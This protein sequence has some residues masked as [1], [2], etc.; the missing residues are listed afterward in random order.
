MRQGTV[1]TRDSSRLSI[2]VLCRLRYVIPLITSKEQLGGR[3]SQFYPSL[4]E[5]KTCFEFHSSKTLKETSAG[6]LLRQTN[7][8][9]LTIFA[10][11][12][13]Q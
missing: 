5:D 1:V 6:S 8:A 4:G 7:T 13:L 10:Q 3:S 11:S 12:P 9:K 2:F